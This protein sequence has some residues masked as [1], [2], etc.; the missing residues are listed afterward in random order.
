MQGAQDGSRHGEQTSARM[1][2][3]L[4]ACDHISY[5]G[6]LHGSGRFLIDL[7]QILRQ[8]GVVVRA[9]VLRDPGGLAAR[10]AAQGLPLRVLDSGRFSPWPVAALYA[11]ARA[12]SADLMH[13][14]D[15]GATTWGQLA[16]LAARLPVVVHVQSH[17][18]RLQRRGFPGYVRVAYR[19]LAPLAARAV[20]ISESVR[21]FATETMGFDEG[22]TVVLH[23]PVRQ[24]ALQDVPPDRV[25]RLRQ[26]YGFA[27]DEPVI[28][29]VTR[30]FAVKGI[31]VLIE[32]FAKALPQVPAARLLIVGDG[33]LRSDLE[34]L[35]RSLGV[36]GRVVFAGF[37]DDVQT[38]YR[39]FTVTVVPSR[40][41]GLGM[42]A[43]ESLM[44]G[45]PVIA[46]REGGLTE[47]VSDG[48]SGLLTPV[49]DAWALG[50]ALWQVLQAPV[51]LE[52]LRAGCAQDAS[53]FSAQAFG[54][55]M[56][57]VYGEAVQW[58]PCAGRRKRVDPSGTAALTDPRP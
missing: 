28:G 45:T 1:P 29:T 22:R 54:D 17:H 23:N 18:S 34:A 13:V 53:R 56:E 31:D 52:R 33:P 40:E 25:E 6:R 41:E 3:V 30:L 49:G 47:V 4:V 15:F 32:A 50:Y 5:D 8:R 39:L 43:V 2:R 35:A 36:A 55:A 14:W 12:M 57:K 58:G 19:L 7:L 10:L 20:V 42:V 24:D 38:H 11:E 27:P 37:T 51:L 48:S 26:R 16:G 46:S 44:A 9:A 21:A